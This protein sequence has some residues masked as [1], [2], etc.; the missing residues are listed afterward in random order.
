MEKNPF[1]AIELQ[2]ADLHAK[3]DKVLPFI[4]QK[5]D[6]LLTPQEFAKVVKKSMP[7]LW[8]WETEGKITPKIIGGKKFYKNPLK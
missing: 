7:T 5:E 1:T 4:N 8:R 6:E 3:F 2:L